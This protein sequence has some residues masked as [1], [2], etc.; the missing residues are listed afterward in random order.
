VM[1]RPAAITYSFVESSHS[2][3]GMGSLSS[4]C[5]ITALAECSLTLVTTAVSNIL[6]GLWTYA[7]L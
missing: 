1:G 4:R 6:D 2:V 7:L 3:E 5:S